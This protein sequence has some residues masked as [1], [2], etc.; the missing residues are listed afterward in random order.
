[1]SQALVLEDLDWTTDARTTLEELAKTGKRFDAYDLTK[2]DLRNPPN[3]HMWGALFRQAAA[4]GV[5]T[6]VGFHKS[7]RPGRAMGVC[8]IWR[9]SRSYR[10]AE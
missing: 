1:M 4:D 3:S 5:I 8:R 2:A 7:S 6:E 10:S 9:G